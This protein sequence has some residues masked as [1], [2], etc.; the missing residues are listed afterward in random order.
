M[1]KAQMI[2]AVTAKVD[3][4]LNIIESM[5]KNL[6]LFCDDAIFSS[7]WSGTCWYYWQN[8]GANYELVTK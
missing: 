8:D 3:E 6:E 4:Q 7:D 5:K 1:N 2:A